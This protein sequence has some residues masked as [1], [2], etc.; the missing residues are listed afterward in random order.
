MVFGVR[1]PSPRATGLVES[2]LVFVWPDGKRTPSLACGGDFGQF[3]F[4]LDLPDIDWAY[5]ASG[6]VDLDI[7]LGQRS[8]EDLIGLLAALGEIGFVSTRGQ[9]SIQQSTGNWHGFGTAGLAAA[10][11]DWSDRY[12]ALNEIHH[13]EQVVYQ[14]V[15]EGGFYV[16]AA[17]ISAGPERAVLHSELSLQLEGTPVAGTALEDLFEV[18]RA[19]PP[20]FLRSRHEPSLVRHGLRRESRTVLDVS[21]YVVQTGPA[22]DED[23]D[24]V[25]GIVVSNPFAGRR[26]ARAEGPEWWPPHLAD[27]EM[28]ICSLRSWHPLDEPRA[29]YRLE[30][31]EWAETA[32]ALALRFVANW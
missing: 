4:A 8:E 20:L 14:D 1:D 5:G 13:T 24:W 17:D 23:E 19:E 12:A 16:L 29:G 9:W 15:C 21:A 26:E 10:V 32:E 18:V 31:A 25:R 7:P 6:G 2:E 22:N 3:V 28:L 30:R 27:S 11:R